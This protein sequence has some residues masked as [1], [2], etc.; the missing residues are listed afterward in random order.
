MTREV[1]VLDVSIENETNVGENG[2]VF[3]IVDEALR[4][5]L[6]DTVR[7]VDGGRNFG[8]KEECWL[9]ARQKSELDAVARLK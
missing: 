6:H 9:D 5:K 7:K 4:Q 1:P 2:I 8:G 3:I